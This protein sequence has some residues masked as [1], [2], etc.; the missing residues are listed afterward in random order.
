MGNF[1][2]S[3]VASQA[4]IGSEDCVTISLLEDDILESDQQFSAILSSVNARVDVS[5]AV[6]VITNTNSKLQ[7]NTYNNITS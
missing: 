4:N 1:F 7:N 6:I 3:F 5:E 2:V